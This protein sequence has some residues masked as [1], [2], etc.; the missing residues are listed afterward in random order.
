MFRNGQKA[1]SE[2]STLQNK[3]TDVGGSQWEVGLCNSDTANPST[4]CDGLSQ[5]LTVSVKIPNLLWVKM[6]MFLSSM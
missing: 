6:Y 3:L 5:F 4:R 2:Y 1:M